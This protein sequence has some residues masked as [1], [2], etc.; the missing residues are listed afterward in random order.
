MT[1]HHA[2]GITE[3][4][5]RIAVAVDH[6]AQ[7]AVVGVAVLDE[8]FNI[9]I[10]HNALDVAQATKRIVVMQLDAPAAS[11]ANVGGRAVGAG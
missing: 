2:F 9:F 11:V 1:D 3:T 6:F 8:G 7:L 10:D 4:A 5:H